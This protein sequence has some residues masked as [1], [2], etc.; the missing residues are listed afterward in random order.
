[1]V[2]MMNEKYL[3]DS[4]TLI[5]WIEGREIKS[6]EIQRKNASLKLQEELV[7]VNTNL[8]IDS[9]VLF[10]VLRRYNMQSKYDKYKKSI[11]LQ[12]KII[13]V[14][15][16]V[17]DTALIVHKHCKSNGLTYDDKL[18]CY[19]DGCRHKGRLVFN[20][21]DFIH[22]AVAKLYGLDIISA[23]GDFANIEEKCENLVLQ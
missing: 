12:F 23:D 6:S 3:I 10:E 14:D 4:S 19:K 21:T 5:D 15:N 8:Y 17:Y 11:E 9:L 7:K 13:E 18:L 16:K 20:S 1:M 2:L 22:Y